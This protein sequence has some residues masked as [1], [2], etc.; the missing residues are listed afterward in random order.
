[1]ENRTPFIR[2]MLELL[3]E[4]QNLLSRKDYKSTLL[5]FKI[6]SRVQRE[7]VVEPQV[8]FHR[9]SSLYLPRDDRTNRN[10]RPLGAR[11]RPRRDSKKQQALL[12]L[13]SPPKSRAVTTLPELL[14]MFIVLYPLHREEPILTSLLRCMLTQAC[15]QAIRTNR[16]LDTHQHHCRLRIQCLIGGGNTINALR[17]TH[18]V[19]LVPLKLLTSE[20]LRQR[21]QKENELLLL[22]VRFELKS[23]GSKMHFKTFMAVLQRGLLNVSRWLQLMHNIVN[24]NGRLDQMQHAAYKHYLGD[25]L[26]EGDFRRVGINE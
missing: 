18:L 19:L 5:L 1:M 6:T 11:S 21:Q 3:V 15:L 23:S 16:F 8:L 10:A 26:Q 13:P 9:V 7:W 24:G 25:Q 12:T 4:N 22:V 14:V 17:R 2:K 20:L